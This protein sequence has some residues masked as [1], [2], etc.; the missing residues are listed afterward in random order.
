MKL[1]VII[2]IYSA[3]AT[4]DRCVESILA[5]SVAD[6]ELI[7]VDDGSP[8]NCPQLC[9]KWTAADPRV[10]TIHQ[11]NGGL[12]N[13][14]NKGLDQ[15]TG[16]LI[17]FVDADDFLAPDTYNPLVDMMTEHADI[18]IVEFPVYW[19]YGAPEQQRLH[20]EGIFSDMASYWLKG[21]GYEHAFAWNKIYRRRLFET[22][23]FPL[24]QVFE[25]VAIM[26][27]LLRETRRIVMVGQ[28][29]YYYCANPKGIT[30]TATG[31]DLQFLL[32]AHL[33]VMADWQM[34]TDARYYLHVL[35]IQ[36][37]VC[38]L[39]G[40]QPRLPYLRVSPLADGLN[41][42][43]RMKAVLHNLLGTKNLCRL[44]KYLH[45]MTKVRS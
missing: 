36:M 4:L 42:K 24:G 31:R 32:D 6:M 43:I 35:N 8:D 7:L 28:G 45:A 26:P 21:Y 10:V 30:H 2:P 15:V 14:R 22:I 27:L 38:E 33:K 41:F 34:L 23:R 9:D 17:T 25:D 18:D 12:S 37:D 19:H 20:R 16:D 11:E 13:A 1:S 5:Q 29:M 3:E 39:T 44:N 40:Q